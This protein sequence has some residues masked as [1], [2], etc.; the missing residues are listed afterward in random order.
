MVVV[1]MMMMVVF[2]GRS[3]PSRCRQCETEL[4]FPFHHQQQVNGRVQL[5]RHSHGGD[6]HPPTELRFAFHQQQQVNGRVQLQHHSPNTVRAINPNGIY[7]QEH[8]TWLQCI[9][10]K[11][12]AT[13]LVPPCYK[14]VS[15]T[16][17]LF[18]YESFGVLRDLATKRLVLMFTPYIQCE[19][20]TGWR[21]RRHT[22]PPIEPHGRAA[23][24]H[25]HDGLKLSAIDMLGV[26][27]GRP[28]CVPSG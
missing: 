3:S 4:R 25:G 15:F 23:P 26:L 1:V 12:D 10:G 19:V 14:I 11:R 7:L 24:G 27:D 21:R 2:W 22:R 18:D 28:E 9:L 8:I 5:P 13:A 6:K 20:P 17:Q 16:C